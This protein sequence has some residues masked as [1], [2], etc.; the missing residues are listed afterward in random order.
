MVRAKLTRADGSVLELEG[1][2]EEVAAVLAWER[3]AQMAPLQPIVVPIPHQ[4]VWPFGPFTGDGTG[5]PLPP[6]P[7]V[8]CGDPSSAHASN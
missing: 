7:V 3:P 8:I 2:S 6:L 4:P 1:T 5:T